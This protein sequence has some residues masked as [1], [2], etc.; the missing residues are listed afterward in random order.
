MALEPRVSPG[1][2]V[3][4]DDY[5]SWEPCARAVDDYRAERGITAPIHEVDWTGVWWQKEAP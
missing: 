5:K 3:L 2:F 4:V 1:G